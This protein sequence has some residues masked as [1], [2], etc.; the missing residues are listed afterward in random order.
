MSELEVAALPFGKESSITEM[1]N[2][3][4]IVPLPSLLK[5]MDILLAS[6]LDEFIEQ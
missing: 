2:V 1:C 4:V 3:R 5:V 6:K